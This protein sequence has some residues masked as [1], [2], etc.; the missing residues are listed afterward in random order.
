MDITATVLA[1]LQPKPALLEKLGQVERV[2][3]KPVVFDEDDS[4][5]AGAG[6]SAR[7]DGTVRLAPASADNLG[8]VGEEIMH[9]HRWTTGY[10]MIEPGALAQQHRYARGLTQLA[11]HF[12]EYAFFP[13]LEGIG[14]DP[15][16]E[17][18]PKMAPAARALGDLLP[19]ITDNGNTAEWRVLLSVSYVQAGLIAHASPDRDRLLAVFNHASL[20]EYRTLGQVL[21]EEVVAGRNENP[22]QVEDRMRRC[23]SQHLNLSPE[24]A[25]VR[26]L[27]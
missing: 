24:A 3:G 14:L 6:G 4:L 26:R 20:A 13:F 7:P 17:L 9:L 11:G 15:R 19:Q 1:R 12:D 5:P 16:Q 22:D 18:T 21:S 27:F 25:V 10:P 23:V 8:V 2:L